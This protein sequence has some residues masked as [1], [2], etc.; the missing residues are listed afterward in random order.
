MGNAAEPVT[1]LVV[2]SPD[3][4]SALQRPDQ[5][6][7]ELVA[8][9]PELL[10]PNT[11]GA[12]TYTLPMHDWPLRPGRTIDQDGNLLAR[13]DRRLAELLAG[14]RH[15]AL[16]LLQPLP[17]GEF[18]L[19]PQ[20][21][22][23]IGCTRYLRVPNPPVAG[24]GAAGALL[25]VIDEHFLRLNNYLCYRV[26]LEP[27]VELE[28]KF[29]FTGNPDIHV[30]ARETI[31]AAADLAFPGWIVEFREEIQQWDFL[32]HIYAINSP[33]ADV[34]Y[35]SFIPTTDGKYTVKRKIFAQDTDERPELRSRGVKIGADL[36]AHVREEMG[37]E[38]DWQATF[39]RIRYDVSVEHV[40][41]G[42]VFGIAF[43]RSTIID[44]DGHR[45]PGAD[46]L[47]QCEIEYIYSQSIT[48]ED[49][50]DVRRDLADLRVSVADWFRSRGL[51]FYETHESKLTWLRNQH[52]VAN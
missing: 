31:A 45:V 9:P 7:V 51:D 34:G 8:V 17:S 35:V 10:R 30:L 42:N 27:D 4:R 6:Q 21:D 12:H 14:H 5:W 47:V 16:G 49:F 32:N 3:L 46:E 41:S 48:A 23:Y 2:G 20:V 18:Q 25:Q 52:A 11:E 36:A 40:G 1:W 29:T 13:S 24:T 38:P 15:V 33:A 26:K 50:A 22:T 37:L 39:R 19:Y 43:D 44:E 28:H